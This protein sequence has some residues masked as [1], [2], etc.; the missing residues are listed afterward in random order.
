MILV[1]DNPVTM[2]VEILTKVLSLLEFTVG[3]QGCLRLLPVLAKVDF[4]LA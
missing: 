2:L 1:V 3:E 4:P